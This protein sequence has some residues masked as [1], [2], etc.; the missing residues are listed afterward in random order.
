MYGLPDST[1]V[2]RKIPKKRFYENI[3]ISPALKRSF[4]EE[5]Q[6]IYWSNK[7]APSTVNVQEG[8]YVKE[9]EVFTIELNGNTIN[10]AVF[11]QIDREIP[12]HILFIL[13]FGGKCQAWIAYKEASCN[14]QTAFKVEVY[15][16]TEWL[17][18]HNLILKVNGLNID[19]VYEDFVRQIAGNALQA[20]SVEPLKES[21]ERDACRKELEKQ[22]SALQ[23][24]V[25]KEKQLNKQVQLNTELKKLRKELE[26]LL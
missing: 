14:N 3:N 18:E 15:Y 13:K 9:L 2:N 7:I 5:I 8:S 1:T 24:K 23:A 16:H 22:I 17:F 26:E 10:E 19:G 21:V 4:V 11:R 20:E 25:R 12:Y 6:A